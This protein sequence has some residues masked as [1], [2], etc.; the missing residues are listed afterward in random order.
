LKKEKTDKK[1]KQESKGKKTL[2][3]A[4]I[5]D[6]HSG[7]R[8]DNKIF[9]PYMK[10]F[11]DEVFFPVIDEQ[12]IS[13]VFHLGDIVDRRSY[14]NFVTA[15]HLRK[16]FIYPLL[17]RK[18]QFHITAGNHDCYYKNTNRINVYH[19]LALNRFTNINVYTEPKII[20]LAGNDV[21][22]MPWICDETRSESMEL[23]QSGI[24]SMC[25]G[26]LDINGF[27]MNSGVLARDGLDSKL[28]NNFDLVLSGH[29]HSRQSI[30]NITY[31]GSPF[32]CD[33]GD[34][35]HVGGFHTLDTETK[36]LKFYPNPFDLFKK[37]WYNDKDKKNDE[38]MDVSWNDYDGCYCKVIVTEKTNPYFFDK[39]ID[40]LESVAVDVK[41]VEDH[42]NLDE[43]DD[44]EIFEDVEDTLTL[45]R[46][47]IDGLS[48]NIPK[49]DM[50]KEMESI[51]VEARDL[52]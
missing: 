51:Y 52:Q 20:N 4:L 34:Y 32:Q 16:D 13:T 37:I 15:N 18:I 21:L 2:L 46:N 14:I 12:K 40:K 8:R 29:F 1:K 42:M 7:A 11:Y 33:W 44:E 41:V 48:D 49:A 17:K 43:L 38:V 45:L 6:S 9:Y 22:L 26:H 36:E 23:I 5:T 25:F 24:A 50:N 30:G 27:S 10:K 28:F 31:L 3:I 19:E 39:F 35:G 47:S